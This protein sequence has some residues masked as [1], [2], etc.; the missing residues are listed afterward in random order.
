MNRIYVVKG[1]HVTLTKRVT[2]EVTRDCFQWIGEKWDGRIPECIRLDA[3]AGYVKRLYPDTKMDQFHCVCA[4]C[5]YR[6]NNAHKYGPTEK[7]KCELLCPMWTVWP[8]KCFVSG[9]YSQF[10]E[11][12][13]EN[14]NEEAKK[15]ALAIAGEA[16]KL[17]KK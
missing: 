5:S 13:S 1:K 17:L 15:C 11:A 12:L 14:K 8:E 7:S 4:C 10:M 16:R 9:P 2:L 3:A 6:D